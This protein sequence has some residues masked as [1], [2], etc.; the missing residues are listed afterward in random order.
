MKFFFSKSFL[1]ILLLNSCFLYLY[2]DYYHGS[3]LSN[4]G[5]FFFTVIFVL[6][7][8][9]HFYI[10]YL[11]YKTPTPD[12]LL[13]EP[14]SFYLKLTS[15]KF[16]DRIL[17]RKYSTRTRYQRVQDLYTQ[18]KKA[19][20]ATTL[21]TASLLF[22]AQG[23]DRTWGDLTGHTTPGQRLY[24]SST[25]GWVTLDPRIKRRAEQLQRWGIDPKQFC[26]DGLKELDSSSINE[27]YE[28]WEG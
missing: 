22:T 6:Y 4:I 25:H 11:M 28:G 14:P 9:N 23:T 16:V 8:L 1:F 2:R 26:Y 20:W 27:V 7:A 17:F 12:E 3:L 19:V 13:L 10:V 18:N 24:T 15:F 5:M 21:G